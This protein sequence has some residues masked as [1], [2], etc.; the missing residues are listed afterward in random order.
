MF[1]SIFFR[2]TMEVPKIRSKQNGRNRKENPIPC[3]DIETEKSSSGT[4]KSSGKS[5]HQSNENEVQGFDRGLAPHKIFGATKKYG[6]LMFLMKWQG[7]GDYF[8]LVLDLVLASEANVKCPQ[9]VINFYEDRLT[10]CSSTKD[11]KE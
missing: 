10:F 8:D 5:T 2:S 4:L 3:V 7:S 1:Q 9:I 11:K 6:E